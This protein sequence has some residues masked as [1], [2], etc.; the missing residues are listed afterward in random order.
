MHRRG[1]ASSE[2]KCK[3]IASQ[4]NGWHLD[5]CFDPFRSAVRPTCL[6]AITP[7]Q[8]SCLESPLY[9]LHKSLGTQSA[10]FRKHRTPLHLLILFSR[11]TQLSGTP[12]RSEAQGS[13]LSNRFSPTRNLQHGDVTWDSSGGLRS[14]LNMAPGDLS[15]FGNS[16]GAVSRAAL[17]S[18]EPSLASDAQEERVKASN[19]LPPP[20]ASSSGRASPVLKRSRSSLRTKFSQMKAAPPS[21]HTTGAYTI[22]ITMPRG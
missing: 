22:S 13:V 19:P 12:T 2:I 6:C 4:C 14:V 16:A 5:I 21:A 18:V 11:F 7:V 17:S 9:K 1:A 15:R 3:F 8:T 10:S 20:K